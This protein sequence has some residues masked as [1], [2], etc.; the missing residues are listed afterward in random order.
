MKTFL[1]II[2][3]VFIVSRASAQDAPPE[4]VLSK[5]AWKHVGSTVIV[6]DYDYQYEYRPNKQYP[7][8]AMVIIHL[9]KPSQFTMITHKLNLKDKLQRKI[10]DEFKKISGKEVSNKPPR[11]SSIGGY[12]KVF[13]YEGRPAMIIS[14]DNFVIR[15]PVD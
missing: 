3:L 14:P 1:K 9:G 12:G 8:S 13:V 5:D 11:G 4:E 2:L 15:E 7:D 10:A 6:Y